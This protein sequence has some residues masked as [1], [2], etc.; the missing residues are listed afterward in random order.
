MRRAL[1]LVVLLIGVAACSPVPGSGGTGGT[2][3]T[4]DTAGPAISNIAVTPNPVA[5]GSSVTVSWH[6]TDASGVGAT[7]IVMK[8]ATVAPITACTSTVHLVSGTT[9]DGQYAAT[10]TIPALQPGGVYLVDVN[11][12]DVKGNTSEDTSTTFTVT[13]GAGDTAPP[14]VL[15]SSIG[16]QSPPSGAVVTATMHVTDASGVALLALTLQNHN[17]H[18]A[19][20]IGSVTQT[21]GTA[22]DGTYTGSISV[23]PGTPAGQYDVVL[24]ATDVLNNVGN[25][26]LGTIGLG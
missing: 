23:I 5:A 18:A 8:S 4:G 25:T 10:C 12:L 17:S 26:T 14:L 3:G 15:T 19:V 9:L 20:G 22:L 11:A 16:L 24:G 13:G 2:G 1:G 21:S 6:L 7:T